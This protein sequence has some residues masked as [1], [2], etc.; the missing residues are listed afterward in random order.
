MLRY[1][2]GLLLVSL[3][4]SCINNIRV[5]IGPFV[6]CVGRV[7]MCTRT[8]FCSS[9]WVWTRCGR[10]ARACLAVPRA[11]PAA[12]LRYFTD[13]WRDFLH[14]RARLSRL[15]PPPRPRAPPPDATRHPCSRLSS[16]SGGSAS[17][18]GQGRR[19]PRAAAAHARRSAPRLSCV[20]T[21]RAV[22]SRRPRPGPDRDRD[23]AHGTCMRRPA[24]SSRERRA[25]PAGA[26]V[27]LRAISGH[28]GLCACAVDAA[29]GARGECRYQRALH[30]TLRSTCAI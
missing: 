26:S 6:S 14:M 20:A 21:G 13:R 9:S 19:A 30:S 25:V 22:V 12:E 5:V 3:S 29:R 2:H 7:D 17:G 8:V 24:W 23:R 16:R 11:L 18:Q 10:D 27:V 4:V 28:R 1:V 15:P